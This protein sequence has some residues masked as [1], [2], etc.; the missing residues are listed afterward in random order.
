[1]RGNDLRT[2]DTT[3]PRAMFERGIHL[4][5]AFYSF[6]PTDEEPYNTE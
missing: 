3:N 5:G 1:M 6:A 2:H 4:S